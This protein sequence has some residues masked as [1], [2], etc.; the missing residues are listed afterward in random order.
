MSKR[1][2]IP[3]DLERAVLVECGHRCAIP[4]CRQVPVELAHIIPW[5]KCKEHTFDNLIALCPTCH[6]RYDHGEIDRKS[7]EIYK[8]NLL[9]S[10]SRYGDLEQRVI[11]R[12][13]KDRSTDEFWWFADMDILLTY[14]VDDGLLEETGQTRQIGGLVQKLYRLT[15]KGLDYVAQWPSS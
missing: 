13:V 12:F 8:L 4:T 2:P 7:M 11:R 1:P 10:N 6:T 15:K 14:L 3:A 5:S 9:L